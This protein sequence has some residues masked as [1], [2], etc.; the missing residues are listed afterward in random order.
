MLYRHWT[1]Y[2][3]MFHSTYI[4]TRLGVWR[5]PGEEKLRRFIA[6]MGLP[7][8]DVNN[9]FNSISP[10]VR[11]RFYEQVRLKA[12]DFGLN[13]LYFGSF[14]KVRASSRPSDFLRFGLTRCLATRVPHAAQC[15][16]CG[17]CGDR[18]A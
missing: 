12:G 17:L 11:D 9:Q 14:V 18:H 3:S 16:R 1:L 15:S 5:E 2:D 13:D 4:A 7:W 8:S 10:A 6:T